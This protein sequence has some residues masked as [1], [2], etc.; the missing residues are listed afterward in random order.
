MSGLEEKSQLYAPAYAAGIYPQLAEK[1]KDLGYA[2]AIHGSLNR[3]L[4]IVAI[5]WVDNAVDPIVLIKELC[6]IFHIEPNHDINKPEV[7]PHGRLAWSLPLWWG[8]YI[9]ISVIT[10]RY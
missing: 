4:D 9:D 10:K 5:P 8:A 7:K 3:D 6:D 1:A 2:L